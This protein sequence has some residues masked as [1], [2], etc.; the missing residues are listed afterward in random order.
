MLSAM[1]QDF[2]PSQDGPLLLSLHGLNDSWNIAVQI[3][4]NGKLK[5]SWK[6]LINKRLLSWNNGKKNIASPWRKNLLTKPKSYSH[7]QK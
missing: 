4:P 3:G 1:K 5:L 2:G 6:P 7:H